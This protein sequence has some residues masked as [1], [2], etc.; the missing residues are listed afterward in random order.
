MFFF[1]DGGI[2]LKAPGNGVLQSPSTIP[3]EHLQFYRRDGYL[4]LGTNFSFNFEWQQN[5]FHTDGVCTLYII[6]DS[7]VRG[8]GSYIYPDLYSK[9]SVSGVHE[10]LY[11][12]A[13][14]SVTAAYPGKTIEQV[15]SLLP[16][17]LG[18]QP[19]QAPAFILFV[20]TNDV[21]SRWFDSRSSE[22]NYRKLVG[23][24]LSYCRDCRVVCI[25]LLPC[26]FDNKRSINNGMY[27][28]NIDINV[29]LINSCIT[30]LVR[31]FGSRVSC[32]DLGSYFRRDGPNFL[33]EYLKDDRLHLN[34]A[35]YNYVNRLIAKH[36]VSIAPN[37]K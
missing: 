6:G 14:Y 5:V 18:V 22:E 29:R 21:L 17:E 35:G 19:A 1:A 4:L 13:P 24:V 10:Q 16:S 11:A 15:Y 31:E 37:V 8:L 12:V 28:E 30:N 25:S 23:L 7:M 9:A 27:K 33:M 32:L 26:Y 36:L 3:P 2:I 20:G 34:E